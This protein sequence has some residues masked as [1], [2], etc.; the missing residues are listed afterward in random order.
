MDF[1]GSFPAAIRALPV[2]KSVA[3]AYR[4]AAQGCD[5]MFVTAPAGTSLP[6]HV[7]DTDN[8]TV[9]LSGHLVVTLAD[10]QERRYGPGD[11]YETHAGEPHAVRFETGGTHIEL[12]FAKTTH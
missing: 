5:V 9:I 8:A 2:A 3:T 10:G 6:S 4:L 1:D 11:W 7:H 12:R